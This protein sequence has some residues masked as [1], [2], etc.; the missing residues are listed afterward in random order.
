[1]QA[2]K[3]TDRRTVSH[4]RTEMQTQLPVQRGRNWA[5][6]TIPILQCGTVYKF[7]CSCVSSVII[8]TSSYRQNSDIKMKKDEKKKTPFV[9][10]SE[11]LKSYKSNQNKNI[12]VVSRE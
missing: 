2:H 9:I 8:I 6:S 5:K 10:E 4:T 3:Q 12:Y 11:N 1:M 7:H